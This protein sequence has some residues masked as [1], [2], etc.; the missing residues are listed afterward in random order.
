VRP[1]RHRTLLRGPSTSPLDDRRRMRVVLFIVLP[2]AFVI[3]SVINWRLH[4]QITRRLRSNHAGTWESLGRPSSFQLLLAPLW[5]WA[6]R[7]YLPWLLQGR[8]EALADSQLS[9]LGRKHY[10][11]FL[12]IC[13]LLLAWPI[14]AWFAG[15]LQA[16]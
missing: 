8:Y 15:Y 14:C 12:I 2:T 3:A 7:S 6:P 16:R 11:L 1:R 9:A 4:S 10:A 13:C 5:F